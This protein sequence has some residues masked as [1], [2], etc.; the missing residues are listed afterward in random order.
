MTG[1]HGAICISI[2]ISRQ[3]HGQ[4]SSSNHRKF[5]NIYSLTPVCDK[6]RRIV[7]FCQFI[8]VLLLCFVADGKESN[9][10]LWTQQLTPDEKSL[11]ANVLDI[12]R[13]R[14][15]RSLI[16]AS[17]RTVLS[18]ACLWKLYD[19]RFSDT[20]FPLTILTIFTC[21]LCTLQRSFIC[22]QMVFIFSCSSHQRDSSDSDSS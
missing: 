3:T 14:F 22:D 2:C 15:L 12:L 11:P 17:V 4:I 7:K 20:V 1:R 10:A 8:I 21:I 16:F 13:P 5:M 9:P 18:N 19:N 6:F